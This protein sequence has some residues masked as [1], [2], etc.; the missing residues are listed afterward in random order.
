VKAAGEGDDDPTDSTSTAN[1][2]DAASS[3]A[4]RQYPCKYGAACY[5]K[6]PAHRGK[7][8]HP[9]GPDASASA[10]ASSSSSSS[11]SSVSTKSDDASDAM[12]SAA[13][14]SAFAK[15]KQKAKGGKGNKSEKP[16][17]QFILLIGIRD[18]W[19]KFMVDC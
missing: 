10:S 19:F 12:T 18:R 9:T 15:P 3:K 16:G 2:P 6:N 4:R 8:S 11:S 17:T 5:N 14:A 13:D 1:A 7:Y